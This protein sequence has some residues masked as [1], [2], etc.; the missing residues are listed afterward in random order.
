[1]K[2]FNNYEEAMMYGGIVATVFVVM[3]IT[4]MVAFH[5]VWMLL[6]MMLTAAFMP[7]IFAEIFTEDKKV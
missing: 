3:E 6:A 1:M 5:N 2:K 7:V 4:I